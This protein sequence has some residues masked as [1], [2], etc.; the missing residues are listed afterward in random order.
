ME[1]LAK[2]QLTFLHCCFTYNWQCFFFGGGVNYSER[3][4]LSSNKYFLL[5]KM[6]IIYYLERLKMQQLSS[7][8]AL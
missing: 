4:S 2:M 7:V 3:Y 1:I 5:P 6:K 8:I